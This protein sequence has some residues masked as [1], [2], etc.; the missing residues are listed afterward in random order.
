MKTYQVDGTEV[1][2]CTLVRMMDQ[3]W[4]RS[5]RA[6]TT[7]LFFLTGLAMALWVVNIPA[8]QA[9]TEISNSALGLMLLTLGAGSV[10]GMQVAGWVSDRFGSRRTAALAVAIIAVA[11]NG[12]TVASTGWHLA[13]VLP[14]LGLGTG[15]ITV[16]A[17]DQAVRLQNAYGR[18]IM[19]AFHGFFS[20]AGALGAGLGALLHALDAPL[21]VALGTASLAVALIG[22]ASVP[23][24]LGP[25]E[26]AAPAQQTTVETGAP[27]AQTP[28]LGKA[29]ALA[30]LAFL[31]M[32]AEGT[33]TD[34]SALHAVEH[35][36]VSES[37]A[38]LTY[39]TFAVAMTIGR[40]TA[41]RVVA[42]IGPVALV[43]RGSVVATVGLLTVVL[44]PV[45]AVTLVGWL[46]FGLGLSGIVPQLFTAA[47]NLS[48]ARRGVVL[49]RVVGAG[50]VGL[51]A[52]PAV[53]GWLS[54]AVGLSTALLA[55]ALA[56]AAGV[57]LASIVRPP[58]PR[59]HRPSRPPPTG[60]ADRQG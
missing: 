39:G 35:L 31:L 51:L 48:V 7:G 55:P 27:A 22:V 37:V 20:I 25:H 59:P 2:Q 47:G 10:V 30:S 13:V 36:R 41:D 44:S 34:W 29:I 54:D 53:I 56:C 26:L 1:L 14:V 43:R 5:R 52:G 45:L 42:R 23:R 11:I 50:Y 24:L 40:L 38:S 58:L 9:R 49:S 18:P 3:T 16:A 57:A 6:A 19:S 28:V 46:L 21:A 15:S 8:V 17:N 32:L 33:A 60:R 4:L 12:P